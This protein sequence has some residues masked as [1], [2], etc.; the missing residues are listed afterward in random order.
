MIDVNYDIK[1]IDF[2][3][4]NT[5]SL[6]STLTTYCGS[7]FYAAPEM[8][9]G[10]PY[11]GPEVDIWS[12]GVI[13]YSM[14]TA[15]LP[16]N[17]SNINELY[18]AIASGVYDKCPAKINSDA[19]KLLSRMLCVK[20]SERITMEEIKRHPWVMK[21]FKTQ[22]INNYVPHRPS[23]LPDLDPMVLEELLD[24]GYDPK[25]YIMAFSKS[26]DSSPVKS[27]YHLHKE[28]LERAWQKQQDTSRQ[29]CCTQAYREAAIA[30]SPPES[31]TV[32][33]G[34]LS[35]ELDTHSQLSPAP[36][37]EEGPLITP[38]L[39]LM[40]LSQQFKVVDSL[41]KT[42]SI[43]TP[44]ST[45]K[46]NPILQLWQKMTASPTTYGGKKGKTSPKGSRSSPRSPPLH[47]SPI[48]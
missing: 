8:T 45:P 3:F 13:L 31:P 38:T 35:T 17:G 47:T 48:K 7:P 44:Q 43:S 39:A 11:T 2:G 14:L 5:F 27:L 42:S 29:P 22:P 32:E 36:L 16:F 41:E 21:G 46:K 18:D 9:Q 12:M 4:G 24:L 30:Y 10:V 40:N 26:Y 23:F 1:L 28:M 33:N 37:Q 34:N 25:D 15:A 19:D 20:P 6:T